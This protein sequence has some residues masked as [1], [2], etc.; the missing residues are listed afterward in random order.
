MG[1]GAMLAAFLAPSEL[2]DQDPGLILRREVERYSSGLLSEL[3]GYKAMSEE[4]KEA[5]GPLYH[6]RVE[7]VETALST[8][9]TF[10]Q[11]FLTREQRR[12]VVEVDRVTL[13]NAPSLGY[14]NMH[15]LL[16]Q[17]VRDWGEDNDN[18]RRTHHDIILAEVRAATAAI[19]EAVAEGRYRGNRDGLRVLTPGDALCRLSYDLSRT[20]LFKEVEANEGSPLFAEFGHFIL[21]CLDAPFNITPHAGVWYNQD[22]V[23]GHFRKVAVP[24]PFPEEAPKAMGEKFKLT[25]GAFEQLYAE[26][27]DRHR[28]FDVLVT[29]FFLDTI[30]GSITRALTIIADLL[31]PGGY[32]VNYGPLLY[33]SDEYPKLSWEEIV[34][35]LPSRGLEVV[36]SEH[37][38]HA[39][40]CERTEDS[41]HPT[42]YNPRLLVA[43]KTV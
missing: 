13:G 16:I 34:A 18:V 27:G 4:D 14:C 7:G 29:S 11:L 38:I 17:F 6:S 32:W 28:H 36:K 40:Y 26:G 5:L 41:L 24:S 10:Y 37:V 15:D 30:P 20:G 42:V 3:Q 33:R 31:P 21:N 2:A 43:R 25:V 23:G 12:E 22:S 39:Q 35:L 8:T 19:A 1:V 9:R